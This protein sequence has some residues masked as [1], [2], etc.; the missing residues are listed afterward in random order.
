MTNRLS[1]ESLDQVRVPVFAASGGYPVDPTSY[2]VKL[3][4]LESTGAPQAADWV[5]GTW[6]TT[7]IGTYTAQ[8]LVGPSGATTLAAGT[9]YVWVQ[10]TGAGEAPVAPA[11]EL[12]VY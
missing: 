11:G 8:C 6:D 7:A 1:T 2:A 4:F 9:Y 5:D 10:I 12:E 3:A